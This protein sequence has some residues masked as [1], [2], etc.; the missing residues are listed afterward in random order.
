LKI[1]LGLGPEQVKAPLSAPLLFTV[2]KATNLAGTQHLQHS[3]LVQ[4][5][6]YA[7]QYSSISLV[8]MRRTN[9]FYTILLRLA[10][11]QL[12]EFCPTP[13][14]KHQLFSSHSGFL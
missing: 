10:A 8:I 6:K 9:F 1:T 4:F 5:H 12:D 14:I 7:I 13:R 2:K 11:R 3:S